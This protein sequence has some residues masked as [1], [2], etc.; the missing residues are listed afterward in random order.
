[1]HI[2]VF[3]NPDLSCDSLPLRILPV[4]KKEFPFLRFEIQDP[5]ELDAPYE[6]QWVIIDTVKDLA[7]VSWLSINDISKA[8]QRTTVHDFDLATHLHLIRK[9]NKKID[10]RIIGIPMNYNKEKAHSETI[11]LLS[12]L[13][14]KNEKRSSC[15]DH[16]RE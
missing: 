11:T 12:S 16:K 2:S 10:I 9:L 3:G 4:L 5:H 14:S 1:M 6:D 13:I 15:R 7:K 8:G